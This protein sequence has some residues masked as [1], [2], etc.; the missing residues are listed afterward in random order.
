MII[1][2]NRKNGIIKR[3]YNGLTDTSSLSLSLDE[4]QDVLITVVEHMSVIKTLRVDINHNPP[5]LVSKIG[6]KLIPE[7]SMIYHGDSLIFDLFLEENL[8]ENIDVMVN[9]ELFEIPAG[10]YKFEIT[11]V[12]PGFYTVWIKDFRYFCQPVQIEVV[13]KRIEEE[14]V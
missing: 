2:Y 13:E 1:V 5:R 14:D 8:N 9:N 3:S 11:F 7:K 10:E 12:A 6:A 4:E